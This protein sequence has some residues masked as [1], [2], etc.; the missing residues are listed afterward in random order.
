MVIKTR[1]QARIDGDRHYFTGKPCKYGH[2]SKRSCHTARCVECHRIYM[3]IFSQK[4]ENKERAQQTQ[5]IYYEKT[6]ENRLRSTKRWVENNRERSNQIKRA[7]KERNKVSVSV[8]AARYNK[9]RRTDP[10]WQLSKNVSTA[11]WRNLKT[12]KG[13]KHWELLVTFTKEELILHLQKQFR[14]EMSWDNYGSVWH[15]DHIKPIAA[16]ESFEEAWAL[17][18][19]QPLLISENL[20]KNSRYEGKRHYYKKRNE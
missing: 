9:A 3:G 17:N 8:D 12:C 5:K 6:K 15:L 20:S 2:L 7:W 10:F 13:G 1:K 11:I 19:L 14:D 18:N 4:R 16:C